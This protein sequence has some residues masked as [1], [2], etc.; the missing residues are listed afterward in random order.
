MFK[1]INKQTLTDG[2]KRF[3]IY[4]PFIARIARPGQFVSVCV[5][6]EDERIPMSILDYHPEQGTISLIVQ[7]IGPTSRKL[8]ELS[9]NDKIFSMIG[10]LG[11]AVNVE[12]K[13]TVVCVATGI[14]VAQILPICR[15]F[16]NAKNKVIGIVGSRTRSRLVLEP[17]L[18]LVCT[19]VLVATEDGS[20][21]RRAKATDLFQKL[22]G[23]EPVDYV[24][25][26]GSG[27]MMATVCG[28][29]APKKILT[30]VQLSPLMIDC[31]GMCGSCRV[32]VGGRSVLACMEGPSFDG[33][34]VDFKDYCARIRGMDLCDQNQQSNQ[35]INEPGIFRKFLSDI[36]SD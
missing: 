9:I 23:Q 26:A 22:L 28:L 14:G 4:A 20:F 31:V 16:K 27:E 30:R 21:G 6:A 3:D 17:Q 5:E 1:V 10:P 8:G 36:L 18:R 34:Q 2:V 24:Y 15:A 29:T 35:K 25:A 13:G 12:K 32:K 19:D 11:V 33:H 7:E